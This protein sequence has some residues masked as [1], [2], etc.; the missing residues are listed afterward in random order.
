MFKTV[1]SRVLVDHQA[2]IQNATQH[3]GDSGSSSL[4][5]TAL[6]F[7]NQNQASQA[8]V[9]TRIALS[10]DLSPQAQHTEPINEQH[11]QN[12][13]A[14]AYDKGKASSLDAGSIGA[15]AAMQVCKAYINRD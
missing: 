7:I 8:S 6:G 3:S 9:F 13:H 2:A 15:A 5:T 4:F 14:E 11:V 10:Q 1:N 12:A